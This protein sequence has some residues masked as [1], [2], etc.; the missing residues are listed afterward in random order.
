MVEQI[1]ARRLAELLHAHGLFGHGEDRGAFLIRDAVEGTG[2]I[3]LGLDR[4]ID[5]PGS[6]QPIEPHGIDSRALVV[7]LRLPLGLPGADDLLFHERGK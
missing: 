6:R 7:D 3:A 5:A 4:L 1:E 2:N